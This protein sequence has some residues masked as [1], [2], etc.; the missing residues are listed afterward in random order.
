MALG[1]TF[2]QIGIRAGKK[3][4]KH[5]QVLLDKA[6]RC[7]IRAL[8]IDPE[9]VEAKAALGVLED[10]KGNVRAALQH[11]L[12]A[13][14]G[15]GTNATVNVHL[16]NH[17]FYSWKDSVKIKDCAS[18]NKNGFEITM[19]SEFRDRQPDTNFKTLVRPG[20]ELKLNR[21]VMAVESV[22]KHKITLLRR[23][24]QDA[25]TSGTLQF[26]LYQKTQ[27][28]AKR[29][30][31]ATENDKII[32]EAQFQIARAR[33]ALGIFDKAKM[34]YRSSLE[35]NQ[36]NVMA[37]YGYAQLLYGLSHQHS[38]K[39][40]R[41]RDRIDAIRRL[42]H[43]NSDLM[44]NN[45]S[46]LYLI[47]TMFYYRGTLTE[48]KKY[49]EM[50]TQ[51]DSTMT[52]GW[53]MLSMILITEA[54][55]ARSEGEKLQKA[56]KNSKSRVSKINS[57]KTQLIHSNV[58]Q[59]LDALQRAASLL[60]ASH[61]RI[62]SW[63]WNN[64]GS[65]RFNVGV[66]KGVESAYVSISQPLCIDPYTHTHTHIHTYRYKAAIAV[67]DENEDITT[68]EYNLALYYAKQGEYKKATDLHEKILKKHP[69]F[70]ESMLS[71]GSI[72]EQ[73]NR[74]EVAQEWYQKGQQ[75][76]NNRVFKEKTFGREKRDVH[77]LVTDPT[78]MLGNLFF[79]LAKMNKSKSYM[80]RAM[81]LYKSVSNADREDAYSRVA[82]GTSYTSI[83]LIYLSNLYTN[84]TH[85]HTHTPCRYA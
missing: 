19:T 14:K 50:A 2:F 84:P 16:A 35:K 29:A 64:I 67:A 71:L 59:A 43:I 53:I 72:H 60:N 33:H 63:I 12:A 73:A 79:R 15:S 45:A 27:R 68:S 10:R 21:V 32:S 77:L 13:Q 54:A 57:F 18:V 82:M 42:K 36:S 20:G 9:N 23:W 51:V 1:H 25:V 31:G 3:N 39:E 69:L 65:L 80:N 58:P 85:T 81:E 8:N 75:A 7:F 30:L 70:I 4:D 6:E 62:P 26:K 46:V 47:G 5:G 48:A 55:S 11:F 40:K 22:E 76:A 56:H 17:Y 49:L 66:M 41:D 24:T 74:F 61:K 52:D 44:P 78:I 38:T 34:Y 28:F 83:S 37:Q